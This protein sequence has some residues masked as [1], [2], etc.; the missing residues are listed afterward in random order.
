M[1]TSFVLQA[2]DVT[3]AFELNPNGCSS[4]RQARSSR[5]PPRVGELFLA[6]R[7]ASIDMG[8]DYVS[9]GASALIPCR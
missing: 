6:G 1:P 3:E 9:P 2:A 7:P 4:S 8:R 5:K